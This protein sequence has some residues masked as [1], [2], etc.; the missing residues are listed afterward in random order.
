MNDATVLMRYYNQDTGSLTDYR[1]DTINAGRSKSYNLSNTGNPAIPN[2]GA[3]WQGSLHVESTQLLSGVAVTHWFD[4]ST[5]QWAGAY[6][7]ASSGNTILY[8]P[9]VSR[10][11]DGAWVRSSNIL[12]QN[13][14]STTATV[15]AQFYATGSSIPAMTITADIAAKVMGE[16]HT[17]FGSP[18]HP[19]YTAAAFEAA[20]GN[21]FKGTVVVTS[22][23]GHKVAGVV[24]S[25]W[26]SAGENAASTYQLESNAGEG[27]YMP[28]TPRKNDG[29]WKEW[30]KIVVQNVS[31][32][33]ASITMRFRDANGNGPSFIDTIAANSVDG[34]S[35]RFGSD[36]GSMPAAWFSALGNDFEGGLYIT[37]S[38]PIAV[39]VNLT[40][41]E[42]IVASTYNARVQ[43]WP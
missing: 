7:G 22:I 41:R 20:L 34:Y 3:S 4:D 35:T 17:R 18:T 40:G 15:V 13:L 42:P 24:H 16:F 12:V 6:Q 8:G 26:H 43:D 28:Y 11:N 23:Y 10:V 38:Q 25:F 36:S 29:A 33:A 9:S 37:S 21:D 32:S 5:H 31:G 2:L 19:V 39:A 27:V 14:E 30:S 1:Q